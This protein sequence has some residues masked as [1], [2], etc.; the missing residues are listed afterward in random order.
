MSAMIAA[1]LVRFS[2]RLR[3]FAS[4]HSRAISGVILMRIVSRGALA[5][6]GHGLSDDGLAGV[7]AVTM[8]GFFF[9]GCPFCC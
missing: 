1:S 2:G 5:P 7:V 3:V 8:V 9:M 6:C 4:S